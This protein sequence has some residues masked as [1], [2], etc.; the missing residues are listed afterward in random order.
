M[1]QRHPP[2]K[3]KYQ[4]KKRKTKPKKQNSATGQRI[5]K[6]IKKISS[7]YNS[8][9]FSLS[10]TNLKAQKNNIINFIDFHYVAI[11]VPSQRLNPSS[12]GYEFHNLGRGLNRFQNVAVS[13]PQI[14]M[15]REKKLSTDILHVQYKTIFAPLKRLNS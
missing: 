3:K 10:P 2:R 14:N 11:L 8:N 13:F 1:V 4:K 12:R 15:G 7:G 5:S 9:A 6:F